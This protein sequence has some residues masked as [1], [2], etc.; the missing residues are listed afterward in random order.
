MGAGV[1]SS[2]NAPANQTGNSGAPSPADTVAQS[3]F[4]KAL[5]QEVTS[6]QTAPER[7]RL[8]P[9]TRKQPPR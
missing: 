1:T 9:S 4:G 2:V 6:G 8:P 5:K 7:V 3:E